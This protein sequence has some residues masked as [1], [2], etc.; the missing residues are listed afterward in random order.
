MA[1]LVYA[2]GFLLV[3]WAAYAEFEVAAGRPRRRPHRFATPLARGKSIEE[4][5]GHRCVEHLE[6]C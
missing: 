4:K 6:G 5:P 1:L 3:S 2:A